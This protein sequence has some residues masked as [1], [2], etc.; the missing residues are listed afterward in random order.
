M[1]VKRK[2]ISIKWKIP[3]K[4]TM[5]GLVMGAVIATV[6]SVAAL[7]GWFGGGGSIP[8][9]TMTRGLV[10]YWNFDEGS[11]RVAHDA[12]NYA[13]NGVASSTWATGKVGGALSFD[14]TNDYVDA[15]NN[16]SLN[17]TAALTVEAWV[18]PTSIEGQGIVSK[19]N[20][21][22]RSYS[23][24]LRASQYPQAALWTSSGYQTIYDTG[25]K[26]QLNT[27]QHLAMTYDG[28]RI[29]LYLNGVEQG[30]GVAQAGTITMGAVN[31]EI[32]RTEGNNAECFNGSIDEVGIYNRALTAEEIRYHY[33][34][35][36]PVAQWKM[37]EGEGRTVYDSTDNNNDGTL[38]LAGSATSSAWV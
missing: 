5:F 10:G 9:D 8:E 13:N 32:G 31:V 25:T 30:S 26:Y 27:W 21:T 11:G 29:R 37:D 12:S 2:K 33:N 18:Y 19:D 7:N 4:W 16:A 20:L 22:I 17:S 3:A 15:G 35:G 1:G 28:S 23:L 38:V 34:R 36:G 24:Y 6:G 14:G